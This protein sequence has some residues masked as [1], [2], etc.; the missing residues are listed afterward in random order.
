ML[1]KALLFAVCLLI[2]NVCASTAQAQWQGLFLRAL[3]GAA[4][5]TAAR[6]AV[7]RSFATRAVRPQAN[8]RSG[9]RNF[10]MFSRGLQSPMFNR[11]REQRTPAY[12]FGVRPYPR[13]SQ[14]FIPRCP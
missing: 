9:L 5:R 6:Q 3:G 8:Y 7:R 10:P 12:R 11:R 1:K 13:R 2:I 4:A 14:F